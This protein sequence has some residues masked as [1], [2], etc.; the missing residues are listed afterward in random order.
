[1]M[2]TPHEGLPSLLTAVEAAIYGS[3]NAA[4]MV[5]WEYAVEWRRDD[6][7]ITGL[8]AALGL[9][10]DDIDALFVRAMAL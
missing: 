8:G 9:T 6:P 1:M 7:Q 5:S 4:L 2:Q 3:N 10:D